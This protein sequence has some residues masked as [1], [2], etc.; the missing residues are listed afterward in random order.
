MH[1]IAADEHDDVGLFE[2]GVRVRRRIESERL[3]VRNDGGGHAL[4]RV[5]VAVQHA[6]AELGECA[7]QRHFLGDDLTRAQK[8]D[9][10]W[11]VLCLDRLHAI[12]ERAE[13]RVPVDGLQLAG[14]VSQ[15]RRHGAIGRVEHGERLPAF[16][17]GHA[18]IH[19]IVLPRAL[20]RRLAPSR[21]MDVQTAPVEQKPQTDCDVRSG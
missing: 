2:V 4:P 19:G 3:L 10:M 20:A 18:Q 5:A 17:A 12:D 9:G 1:E 6:H 14:G 21:K 15:Q 13:R 7:E 16:R 11:A 8:G